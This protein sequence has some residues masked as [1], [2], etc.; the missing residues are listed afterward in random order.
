[1]GKV[2]GGEADRMSRTMAHFPH[3]FFYRLICWFLCPFLRLSVVFWHL[4][5]VHYV[6]LMRVPHSGC[7]G[8]FG[9][10]A[11]VGPAYIRHIMNEANAN[12]GRTGG[13][14]VGLVMGDLDQCGTVENVT[15]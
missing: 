11:P 13:A 15:G 7:F 6:G 14:W 3:Y 2:N 8:S 4:M 12:V 1:M 5:Y 10:G 9:A